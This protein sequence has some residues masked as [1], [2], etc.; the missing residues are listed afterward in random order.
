MKITYLFYLCSVIVFFSCADATERQ[1]PQPE[2]SKAPD[3]MSTSE[4]VNAA[5]QKEELPLIENILMELHSGET[6]EAT[7]HL[8]GKDVKYYNIYVEPSEQYHASLTGTYPFTNLMI[9]TPDGKRILRKNTDGSKIEWNGSFKVAGR[10]TFHVSIMSG[11]ATD[12][13]ETTTHFILTE[14]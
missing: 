1:E 6:Y 5:E 12:D 11:E 2:V 4:V 14:K 13:A 9:F 10:A 3:T 8:K 7:A